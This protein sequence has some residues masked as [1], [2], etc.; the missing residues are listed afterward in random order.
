MD[1]I[2]PRC[3]AKSSKKKFVENFCLDCFKG[4][5]DLDTPAAVEIQVCKKC[6]RV[7]LARWQDKS[8]KAIGVFV[9]KQC[10]VEYD[11]AKATVADDGECELSFVIKAEDSLIEVSEHVGIRYVQTMCDKCSRTSSGYYEAIIQ[12]R[13]AAENV[14]KMRDKMVPVLE[15]DTFIPK[16]VEQKKGVD[17]YVGSRRSAASVLS[18]YNLKPKISNKL[19]GVIDGQRVYRTT[20]SIRL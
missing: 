16:M 14:E 19:H 7:K 18:R 6:D 1:L 17:I 20:F 5:I 2:C 13:G 8:A 12:L 11:T 10:K 3:G 15:R 4:Y 9:L